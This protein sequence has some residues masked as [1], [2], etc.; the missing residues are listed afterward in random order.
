MNPIEQS[1]DQILPHYFQSLLVAEGAEQ[2]LSAYM[3]T[4]TGPIYAGLSRSGTI[5]D[6]ALITRQLHAELDRAERIA[7]TMMSKGL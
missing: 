3:C 5:T 4:V 1:L 6:I 2:G 7:L